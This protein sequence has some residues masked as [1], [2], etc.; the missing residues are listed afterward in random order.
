MLD[1]MFS[2]SV[3]HVQMFRISADK[4]ETIIAS[5]VVCIIDPVQGEYESWKAYLQEEIK[6][7]S[8]GDILRRDDGSELQVLRSFTVDDP[9]MGKVTELDLKDYDP[10]EPTSPESGVDISEAGDLDTDQLH[11]IIAQEVWPM[12]FQENY[13][14]AVLQAFKAVEIA[15]RDAGNYAATDYGTDLMRKAF[16]VNDGNLTD[17]NQQRSE[18]Q[19]RSDLFA[20]AIGSFKNPLSHRDIDLTAQEALELIFF[21]SYL[22]RIID[23]CN[24]TAS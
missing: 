20:G 15:V 19:A 16:N 22:L 5:E 3:E 21:A 10:V 23:S 7:I 8:K 1:E 14:P 4:V 12:F 9:S 2:D 17:Q 13:A 18:R 24:P 11:P 6:N